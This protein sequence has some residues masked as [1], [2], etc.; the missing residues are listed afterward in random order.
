MQL[1]KQLQKNII[2]KKNKMRNLRKKLK[3]L[4]QKIKNG[5][6]TTAVTG[7][8]SLVFLNSIGCASAPKELQKSQGQGQRIEGEV[9]LA[10]VPKRADDLWKE[11]EGKTEIKLDYILPIKKGDFFCGVDLT[12]YGDFGNPFFDG[13]HTNKFIGEAHLGYKIGGVEFYLSHLSAHPFGSGPTVSPYKIGIPYSTFSETNI[14]F[15]TSEYDY[16]TEMGI[17]MKFSGKIGD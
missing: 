6:K 8:A 9:G 1:T 2:L 5:L 7:L 13:V 11:N 17:K 4:P 16:K 15:V 14:P 10:Y 12:A 3:R